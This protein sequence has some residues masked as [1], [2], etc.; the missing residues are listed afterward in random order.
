ML[1]VFGRRLEWSLSYLN[2]LYTQEARTYSEVVNLILEHQIK[3][4]YIYIYI[5]IYTHTYIYIYAYTHKY[6]DKD[7]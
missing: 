6:T 2:I 5:Y 3:I 1:L 7:M 4:V